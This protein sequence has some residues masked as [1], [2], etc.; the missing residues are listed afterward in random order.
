[1]TFSHALSFARA[2]VLAASPCPRA[3][4]AAASQAAPAR[5]RR[6]RRSVLPCVSPTLAV[7]ERLLRGGPFHPNVGV[8]WLKGRRARLPLGRKVGCVGSHDRRRGTVAN[9]PA[10]RAARVTVCSF[11]RKGCGSTL[12][13]QELVTACE[14]VWERKSCAR[15][16]EVFSLTLG[17]AHRR[18]LGSAKEL[19]NTEDIHTGVLSSEY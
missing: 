13:Q 11:E 18:A 16:R 9:G 12:G 19:F 1:M 5:V 15:G 2:L 6:I 14:C 17:D 3:C 10:S 8:R 4:H 7:T